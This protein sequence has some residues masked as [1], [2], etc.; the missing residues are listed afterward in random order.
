MIRDDLQHIPEFSFPAGFSVRF[1][2]PGD[3]DIWRKIHLAADHYNEITPDLFH[4]EFS[5]NAALLPQRQ[6]YLLDPSG[7]PIGTGTAWFKNNF[8]GRTFGRV[9]WLAIIP[10]FQG[11]GLS[12]PL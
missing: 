6:Y 1:Y 3:E 8:Q 11:R 10:E 5:A 2:L 12:K 7:S 9:H 4:R